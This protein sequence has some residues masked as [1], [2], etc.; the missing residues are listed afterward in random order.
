MIFSIMRILFTKSIQFTQF[1]T[2]HYI[3][4][5]CLKFFKTVGSCQRYSKNYMKQ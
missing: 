4:S 5:E 2:K 1:T 3:H